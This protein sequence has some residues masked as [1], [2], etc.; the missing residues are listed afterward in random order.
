MLKKR[1]TS[2]IMVFAMCFTSLSS[3]VFAAEISTN[4]GEAVS[5][6]VLLPDGE[7]VK[8]YT[9][10]LPEDRDVVVD[11]MEE[12]G[13]YPGSTFH[14]AN[15]VYRVLD[16]YQIVYLG[17]EDD[18]SVNVLTDQVEMRGLNIPT[19]YS[20]LPYDGSYNI[21]NYVYSNYRFNEGAKG[22]VES[23]GVTIS[24]DFPQSICVDWIDARND[25]SMGGHTLTTKANSLLAAAYMWVYG[26]EDFYIKISKEPLI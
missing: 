5:L 20:D 12:H 14:V 4:E 1:I 8:L 13:W 7:G 24:T 9:S 25:E 16:D 6:T 2:M 21:K 17:R 23:I 3:P 22:D 15:K 11:Y 26:G 19:R 10:E 18:A